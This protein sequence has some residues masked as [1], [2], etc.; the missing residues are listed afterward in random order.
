MPNILLVV[1]FVHPNVDMVYTVKHTKQ[2]DPK[3]FG[4]CKQHLYNFVY[5]FD[6]ILSVDKNL[7][8]WP[9]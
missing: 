6:V 7:L 8:F 5:V 2:W 9:I 1:L 4:I 3:H